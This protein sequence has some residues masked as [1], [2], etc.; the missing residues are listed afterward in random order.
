MRPFGQA[1]PA[2]A[3]APH[4]SVWAGAAGEAA[5]G[6]GPAAGRGWDHCSL[7]F[8]SDQDVKGL[9]RKG[10]ERAGRGGAAKH[11]AAAAAA[12]TDYYPI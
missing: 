2:I 7:S 11:P 5:R 6:A 10:L 4:D 3:R 8:W 12:A 1:A 9:P